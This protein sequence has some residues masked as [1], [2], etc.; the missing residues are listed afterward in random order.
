[1]TE[2]NLDILSLDELKQL[3]KNVG[4]AI[5]GY[6]QRKR[7]EALIAL[8]AT[9]KEMGF[10]LSE[11]TSAAGGKS[12]NAPKYVHPEEPSKTWTG[13]GR[14]PTWIKEGLAA[15]NSLDAYAI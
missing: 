5:K 8:E 12:I 1:M 9:A 6:E 2:F 13:R 7:K 14:Q 11:L 3:E 15:G 10:S 4:K